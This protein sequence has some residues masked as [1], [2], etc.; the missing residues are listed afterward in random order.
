[1]AIFFIY[2]VVYL[3]RLSMYAIIVMLSNDMNFN[4]CQAL[5]GGITIISRFYVTGVGIEIYFH[6]L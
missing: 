4:K 5:E 1:M 6:R 3:T 2:E